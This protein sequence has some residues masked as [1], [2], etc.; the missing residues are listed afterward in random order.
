MEEEMM[1]E[2]IDLMAE[3]GGEY[4]RQLEELKKLKVGSEEY[5]AAVKGIAALGKL[6]TEIDKQ[7]F[8]CDLEIEKQKREK[9]IADVNQKKDI[10][11]LVIKGVATIGVPIIGW[12][13]FGNNLVQVLKFEEL[14]TITSAAGKSFIGKIFPKFF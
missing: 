11:E 13:V 12:K 3:T 4:L 9:E 2:G 1:E 5:E 7:R 8:D 14:G 10:I 6:L